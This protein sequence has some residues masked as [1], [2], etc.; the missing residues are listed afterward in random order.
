MSAPPVDRSSSVKPT[1]TRSTTKRSAG[2]VPNQH[3][4]WAMLIAPYAVGLVITAIDGRFDIAD[5]TLF[6]LWF[7]GYLAFFATSLWL[8]SR[9]RP[10]YLPPVRA[11]VSAAAVLG[12]ITLALQPAIISWLLPFAP[13]LLI[14]LYF[15]YRR[16]DRSI[17]SGLATVAAASLMPAVVY[18][19]GLFDFIDGVS[20]P[21]YDLIALVCAA[22]FGYF[23][24]TVLYVKTMIRERGSV[25]YVVAS[26][27]WHLACVAAAGIWV[28]G[29]LGWALAAYF[30]AMTARALAMPMMWPM[31]GRQLAPGRLGI[32]ELIATL[33]LATILI[34]TA[35]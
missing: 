4:A 14:G 29:W 21:P 26:V 15:A 19:D 24:G 35:L 6:G 23:F 20:S 31:R 33:A 7:V 18:A 9:R 12:V 17:P 22:S 10:R 30:A 32:V 1:G 34:C 27:L 2:W 13:I 8:K 28:S 11:Y 3:G 16:D 25:G 5:I